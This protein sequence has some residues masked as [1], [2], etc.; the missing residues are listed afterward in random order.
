MNR[1]ENLANLLNDIF[2]PYYDIKYYENEQVTW[3][4]VITDGNEMIRGVLALNRL[5]SNKLGGILVDTCTV[6]C[7][8]LIPIDMY[9]EAIQNLEAKLHDIH[10]TGYEWGSEICEIQ[11]T[12]RTESEKIVVNGVD[13]ATTTLEI[14]MVCYTKAVSGTEAYV[15]L[16]GTK[17]YGVFNIVYA[18]T[19]NKE[20]VVLGFESP[21]QADRLSGIQKA[22]TIDFVVCKDDE[23]QLDLMRNEDTGKLYNVQYWNGVYLRNL[24][25]S[26][27]TF[28]EYVPIGNA[29]KGQV[30]LG[31]KEKG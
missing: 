29:I 3:E 13:Y 20:G 14:T 15:K 28:T 24:K 4:D 12:G 9:N 19:H 23:L 16:N 10:G 31:I 22:L 1:Y 27:T 25:T 6:P 21:V 11:F 8:V 2:G 17:L 26:V 5:D 18:N 7:S 30:V